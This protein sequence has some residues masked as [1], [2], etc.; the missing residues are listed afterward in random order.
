M[1]YELTLDQR[2]ER[3]FACKSGNVGGDTVALTIIVPTEVVRISWTEAVSEMD[4]AK[5]MMW[6]WTTN[7][8]GLQVKIGHSSVI[9]ERM[10]WEQERVGWVD[11]N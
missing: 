7:E 8:M 4:E 10:I 9:T 2:W 5:G 3:I 6:F 1:F 11:G